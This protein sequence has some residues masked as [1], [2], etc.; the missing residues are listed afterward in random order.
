MSLIQSVIYPLLS[1]TADDPKRMNRGYRQVIQTSTFIIFPGMVLLFI[2]A[3]PLMI[4]V[5]GEL[6]QPAAPFL[7]LICVYG[8]LYHLHAI[9]LNVLKVMD[10]SDLFI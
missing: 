10:R 9:N 2:F 6:W 4:Y 8:F 1:Q 5:L 7:Q 3:E